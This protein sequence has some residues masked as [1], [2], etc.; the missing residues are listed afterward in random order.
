MASRDNVTMFVNATI[1]D[2]TEG[3]KPQRGMAVT[4]EAGKIARIEPAAVA[5]APATAR[6]IDLGGAFLMPGLVNMRVHFCG[7]GK[8]MSSGDAGSI[9]SKLDNPVGRAILRR[10]VRGSARQQLASG[11][12]TVR[13]AGDPLYA[14]IAVRDAIEAGRYVGPRIV[15]PGTGVTV[16]GGHGAGLFAQVAESPEQ[17]SEQVRENMARGADVIKLFV[18]GGVF[19]ATEPGEPGVLRMSFEVASAACKTAPS[20][21]FPSWRTSRAPRAFAWRWRPASTRSSTVPP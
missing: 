9:M 11:V 17:A 16:P 20:W 8:P 12:T 15:A 5:Q 14:D 1:L 21:G 19:D 6:V 4:V 13:G 2:G 10:I 3:M 18:T 7:S